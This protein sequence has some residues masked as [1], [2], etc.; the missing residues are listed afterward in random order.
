MPTSPAITTNF[1]SS[2]GMDLGEKLITKDYL[3]SVYPQ[4]LPGLTSPTLYRAGWGNPSWSGSIAN[5][6]LYDDAFGNY[7]NWKT[8]SASK[9]TFNHGNLYH[10]AAIRYDG[11]LWTSQLGTGNLLNRTSLTRVQ[12]IQVGSSQQSDTRNWKDVYC[13]ASYTLA[14]KHDGTLW[15]CGRNHYGQLGLGDTSSRSLFTRVGNDRDWNSIC[16]GEFHSL[17]IKNNGS[18]YSW[19]RNLNGLLGAGNSNEYSTSLPGL[20]GT[21]Y[22]FIDCSN[23]YSYA[24]KNT[25]ELYRW[26]D[27]SYQAST[28]SIFQPMKFGTEYWKS[29]S[30]GIEHS[31]AIRNDNTLWSVG[32][33]RLG[34]LGVGN[35]L[36]TL[37]FSGSSTFMQVYDKALWKHVS[38]GNFFTTAIRTDGSYWVWG[39]NIDK[40]LGNGSPTD[41]NRFPSKILDNNC[42]K[43]ACFAFGQLALKTFEYI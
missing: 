26:G 30:C 19:G 6:D 24:I 12:T 40:Q 28:G 8:I 17:A 3:L 7:N 13:G 42:K 27:M 29:I 33:N 14:L 37:S 38:C 32:S 21:D 43:S 34:A 4:L 36:S 15:A 23:Y 20:I 11:S 22:S 16:A 2:D 5:I 39:N 1:K 41:T 31:A 18:L 25:G 35:E 9:F 10:M